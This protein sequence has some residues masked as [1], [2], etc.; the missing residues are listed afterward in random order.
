MLSF[1]QLPPSS[2]ATTSVPWPT[3][4]PLADFAAAFGPTDDEDPVLPPRIA[5]ELMGAAAYAGDTLHTDDECSSFGMFTTIP[6]N[7]R[8]YLRSASWRKSFQQC[9]FRIYLRL[10]KGLMPEPNCTGE[11]MALHTLFDYVEQD[12]HP[13]ATYANDD[14][15]W[16][17]PQFPNDD[18]YSDAKECCFEGFDVLELFGD[19]DCD[20]S[21]DEGAE[22]V[23]HPRSN[24]KLEFMQSNIGQ[25]LGFA[26]MHPGEWF[27]AF[28]PEDV[29]LEM[30]LL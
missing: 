17:L 9:D 30:G 12:E 21:P 25:S 15:Y 6:T 26:Y 24:R 22:D 18:N 7:A 4:Q 23:V 5:Y 29:W 28:R 2:Y 16:T 11:E 10:S 1:L 14:H 8:R 13:D 20:E 19:E 27:E 3:D